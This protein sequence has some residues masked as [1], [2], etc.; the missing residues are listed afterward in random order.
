MTRLGQAVLEEL[1]KPEPGMSLR[2]FIERQLS[3]L[4][5]D[6][7]TKLDRAIRAKIE[8]LDDSAR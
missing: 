5:Q 8:E 6:I 2:D 3:Q 4:S 7:A 1:P